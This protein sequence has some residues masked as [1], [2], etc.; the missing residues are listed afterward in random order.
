MKT[1]E[2]TDKVEVITA[3]KVSLFNC[4]LAKAIIPAPNAPIPAASVGV[5]IPNRIEPSTK[6]INNK[7]GTKLFNSSIKCSGSLFLALG[8]HSGLKIPIA[9]E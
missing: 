4:L 1:I 8:V 3:C 5:A 6:T 7:G 2:V 9:K